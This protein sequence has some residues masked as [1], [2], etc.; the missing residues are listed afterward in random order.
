MDRNMPR[1]SEHAY[2]DVG[3]APETPP[4]PPIQE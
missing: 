3:M 1:P 2:E 4:Y